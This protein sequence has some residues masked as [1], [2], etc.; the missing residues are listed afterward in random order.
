MRRKRPIEA[1]E[2]R[3][4]RAVA[5]TIQWAK[6]AAVA[7]EHQ[8]AVS[9]MRVLEAVEGELPAELEPLLGRCLA[10]VDSRGEAQ[11]VRHC[12]LADVA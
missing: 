12:R 1:P 7:G 10:V 3:H 5:Q 2:D 9:W 11:A 8:D 6:D 4:R